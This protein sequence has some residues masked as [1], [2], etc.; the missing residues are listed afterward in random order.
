MNKRVRK[1]ASL[2]LALVLL[3]A[4]LPG[5]VFA[6][7]VVAG[8]SCGAEGSN[9]IWS[10]DSEGVMTIS[11]SGAMADYTRDVSPPWQGRERSITKVKISSGVTRA[12]SQAFSGC[13]KRV[14]LETRG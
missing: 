3:L 4:L 11:G 13:W 5:S 2:T 12:G 14:K 7:D 10:L 8:G 1:L 6:A 9:V